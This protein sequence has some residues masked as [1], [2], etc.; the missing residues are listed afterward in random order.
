M[1]SDETQIQ[2]FADWPMSHAQR[3]TTDTKQNPEYIIQ[4]VILDSTPKPL[5]SFYSIRVD[6]LSSSDY[7]Q[8]ISPK[9]LI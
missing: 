1:I 4:H 3:V 6:V 9:Y 5:E 7:Y 2:M 8:K